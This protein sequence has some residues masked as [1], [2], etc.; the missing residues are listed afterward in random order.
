MLAS[1]APGSEGRVVED[2]R[3]SARCNTRCVSRQSTAEMREQTRT[4]M[5]TSRGMLGMLSRPPRLPRMWRSPRRATVPPAFVFLSLEASAF[6]A[7][8]LSA[9]TASGFT[10]SSSVYVTL[11]LF[12]S[13]GGMVDED[14]FRVV[15]S[16]M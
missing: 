16:K 2:T 13:L 9:L 12:L 8:E 11:A 6:T 1:Y 10:S 3:K 5:S 7:L 14:A 15:G 4:S